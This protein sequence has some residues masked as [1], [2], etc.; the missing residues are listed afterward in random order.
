MVYSLG[1]LSLLL[2]QKLKQANM[3]CMRLAAKLKMHQE[4]LYPENALLSVKMTFKSDL[5]ASVMEF[6]AGLGMEYFAVGWRRSLRP[7]DQC[8]PSTCT[9][10]CLHLLPSRP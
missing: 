9:D 3:N 1:G 4:I 6:S 8:S 2:V 5:N 10:L 7:W